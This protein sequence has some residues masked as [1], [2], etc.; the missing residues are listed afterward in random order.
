LDGVSAYA[1]VQP[2]QH[3]NLP[4]DWT[5]ETWFKDEHPAGF[6]HDYVHLINKG[7]RESSPDSTYFMAVGYKSVLV[8]TRAGW[9]DSTLRYGLAR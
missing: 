8:G 2:A 7:D 5:I 1:D 9:I 4:S 6:N 3:L